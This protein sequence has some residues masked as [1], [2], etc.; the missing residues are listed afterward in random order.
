MN[1]SQFNVWFTLL[2][3]LAGCIFVEHK[4]HLEKLYEDDKLME[5]KLDTIEILQYRLDNLEIEYQELEKNILLRES[6]CRADREN[7]LIVTKNFTNYTKYSNV[8]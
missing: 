3:I 4:Y 7:Y 8:M 5:E 2:F 1:H 6:Q